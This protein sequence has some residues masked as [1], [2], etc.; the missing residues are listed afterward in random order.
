MVST[1]DL[2]FM[3]G[4]QIQQQAAPTFD[5]AK[6]QFSLAPT[7]LSLDLGNPDPAI[8]SDYIY[9]L[10]NTIPAGSPAYAPGSA[11]LTS[12]SSTPST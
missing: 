2:W 1:S 5:P 11:L 10:G 3:Y 6:Q 12:C 7:T 9:N 8:V 4:Q